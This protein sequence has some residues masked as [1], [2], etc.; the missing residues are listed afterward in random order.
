MSSETRDAG[1]KTRREGW[2]DK[3]GETAVAGA[4]F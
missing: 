1:L 4:N 3:F 2:G